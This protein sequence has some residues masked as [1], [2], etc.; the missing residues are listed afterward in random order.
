[1]RKLWLA[2]AAFIASTS[3]ACAQTP[4]PAPAPTGAPNAPV[5][6][7]PGLSPGNTASP[8]ST[9]G[10]GT[11]PGAMSP[12]MSSGTSPSPGKPASSET[13]ATPN[14]MPS[15]ATGSSQNAMAPQASGQGNPMPADASTMKYLHIA[16]TAIRHHDKARADDA[17]SN[18][19]TLMLTRAVPQSS[20]M[21]ADDS[22][23]V[24]AVTQARQALKAGDYQQATSQTETAMQQVRSSSQGDG[25]QGA[26]APMSAMPSNG[27]SQ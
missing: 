22:P 23:A 24:A 26:M 3:I 11:T 21:S 6:T 20:A 7:A 27:T 10:P 2:S 5:E 4:S 15:T 9:M 14:H 17:L 13:N 18:A 1:M 25:G 19:E 8:T 12:G 16:R